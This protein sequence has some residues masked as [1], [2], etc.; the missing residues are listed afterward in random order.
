MA[1]T[2]RRLPAPAPPPPAPPSP[3]MAE[4]IPL[5]EQLSNLI[6]GTNEEEYAEPDDTTTLPSW[7][8]TDAE[9]EVVV[10]PHR[11]AAMLSAGSR[12]DVE[13][14]IDDDSEDD[15]VAALSSSVLFDN[16]DGLLL[17][18]DADDVDDDGPLLGADDD[19]DVDDDELLLGAD[20][21]DALPVVF[22][23]DGMPLVVAPE[24]V[25]AADGDTDGV[26]RVRVKV[27][28]SSDSEV[29]E[30]PL[31]NRGLIS[32]ERVY[33][34]RVIRM[35][36]TEDADDDDGM[37]TTGESEFDVFT[38]ELKPMAKLKQQVDAIENRVL[39]LEL[40]GVPGAAAAA[41]PPSSPTTADSSKDG[42]LAFM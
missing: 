6:G 11:P 18:A 24:P 31:K 15:L 38:G 41:S 23:D 1:A 34:P 28:S 8:T 32:G 19:D 4:S 9:P 7:G 40:G 5:L 25:D 14:K 33:T 26:E 3:S 13:S 2:A 36:W 16:D 27:E 39:T 30:D 10:P 12:S 17:G 20:D 35:M 22:P 42:L 37:P 21:A 29:S